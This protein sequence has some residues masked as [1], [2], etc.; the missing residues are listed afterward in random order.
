MSLRPQASSCGFESD[1]KGADTEASCTSS[2]QG[3]ENLFALLSQAVN[4]K[5]QRKKEH[6]EKRV[7]F[8]VKINCTSA[9]TRL[10]L[11]VNLSFLILRLG[12]SII[13]IIILILHGSCADER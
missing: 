13:I 5:I 6:K 4:S 7:G 2:H 1:S 11:S 12:I 9:L 8:G 10:K 3:I